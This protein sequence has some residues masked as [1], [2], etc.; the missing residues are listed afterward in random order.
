[1]SH[2]RDLNDPGNKRYCFSRKETPNLT[3]I[4]YKKRISNKCSVNSHPK[5]TNTFCD[6]QLIP[7]SNILVPGFHTTANAIVSYSG[8]NR[9]PAFP[10]MSS[11]A[12]NQITY[13]T[14]GYSLITY[15][16]NTYD[17]NKS[18]QHQNIE[19]PNVSV[20]T[21]DTVLNIT[22]SRSGVIDFS[23]IYP[24]IPVTAHG[25]TNATVTVAFISTSSQG[26]S[27]ADKNN[28]FNGLS[29]TFTSNKTDLSETSLTCAG[30]ACSTS[31]QI[32]VSEASAT[33]YTWT[34]N[35]N[36][37]LI[38]PADFSEIHV[39]VQFQAVET[40]VNNNPTLMGGGLRVANITDYSATGVMGKQRKWDYHY[41]AS[42]QLSY[43]QLMSFPSY[44]H[45][46]YINNA[47][48][49]DGTDRCTNF[50]LFSSSNVGLTSLAQ[51]NIVGYSQ[52]AEYTID[53]STGTDDGKTI[54]KFNNTPDT[55]ISYAG[56]RLPG[57]L[58]L[59]NNLNGTLLSK[60]MYRNDN[61]SGVYFKVAETDNY[62]HTA[63]KSLYF[64]AKYR[65][66]VSALNPRGDCG[67]TP[68]ANAG[69]AFFFPSIKSERI[70]QNSVVNIAYNLSDTTKLV[71]TS[72]KFNYDNPLHYQVTRTTTTDSR[73][74]RHVEKTTY[75]QDYITGTNTGNAILDSLISHNMVTENI[76]K[77]DSLYNP[78]VVAGYVTGATESRYKQLS[79]L[80]MEMDK[81]YKLDLAYPVTDFTHMTVS[82]NTYSQDSRYRQ[83]I[84]FDAYDAAN[85]V[86]QYTIPGAKPVAILWDYRNVSPIA[87]IKSAA[88]TDVAYTSF[89]ADGSGAWTIGSTVRDSVTAAI[90]GTKSYNLANG[91]I[92]KASLTAATTYVITYWTK[93][94][95]PLTIAG[96]VT[97]FPVKGAII[98]GWTFYEHQV[99]RQTS[100]TL[101]GSGNI[102]ELRLYPVGAQMTSYTYAPLIG[103]TSIN[104]AR[105][106]INYFEYDGFQRLINVKDQYGNIVKHTDYHY[107]N[108]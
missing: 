78:G 27:Q 13:P 77:V 6:T 19:Y 32:A 5:V 23:K 4:F 99:T 33:A 108:Q 20:V 93:N 26:W 68:V 95:A 40:V 41:G 58:N 34:A 44:A 37:S 80:V 64:S 63:N 10:A 74:N 104:D 38:P 47:G 11:F 57:I 97:G 101:S 62:Y 91:S 98:N 18:I 96:T 86:A 22:S 105:G 45:N 73:G 82:G 100:V 16:A 7:T 51:G 56:F 55:V 36:S 88:L 9:E 81:V 12:L 54:Y 90:T 25:A 106:G 67:S 84:G 28:G 29:F 59:A 103:V 70:L 89:E 8:A 60:T 24:V 14:G 39:T 52:V 79:S 3:V 87:Q 49:P 31:Y 65:G 17:Y 61:N 66:S 69:F 30:Q 53:P 2:L 48:Q 43:G 72:Q 42:D 71:L 83:L 102:D 1:L 94:A 21:V 85:N 92:S 46:E 76:E 15:D 35:Y 75:P 50:I 107:Q